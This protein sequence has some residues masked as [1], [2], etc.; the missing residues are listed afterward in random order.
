VF[1]A[2]A[3]GICWIVA[4]NRLS[5]RPGKEDIHHLSLG[6]DGDKPARTGAFSTL[7]NHLLCVAGKGHLAR[8]AI[9]R[10]SGEQPSVVRS[11]PLGVKE[12]YQAVT[13]VAYR[14]PVSGK[15]FA[16]VFHD[17]AGGDE[18]GSQGQAD[19]LQII[20]L[21]PDGNGS[22]DDAAIAWRN[23]VG[24]SRVDGHFGHHS[25]AMDGNGGRAFITN[26]GNGT[27]QV[28][29]ATG[30]LGNKS[31]FTTLASGGCPSHII[32]VGGSDVDD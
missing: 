14:Q 11:I 5:M 6:E 18:A 24:P 30:M 19:S 1:F 28:F 2:P 9:I 22:F 13:P 23:D 32:C 20:E 8:L 12:R 29:P 16:F 17:K 25:I 31:D 27:I 10:A 3:N 15:P 26:S 7:G 21:D 4:D